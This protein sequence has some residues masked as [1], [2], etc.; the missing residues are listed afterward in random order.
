MNNY[1]NNY[2]DNLTLK[3]TPQARKFKSKTVSGRGFIKQVLP[4]VTE[5]YEGI[6]TPGK[7]RLALHVSKLKDLEPSTVALVVL[8]VCL[9]SLEEPMNCLT[10][11]TRVSQYLQQELNYS[12]LSEQTPGLIER[13]QGYRK[14]HRARQCIEDAV[15]NGKF[16]DIQDELIT[17][18]PAEG[19]KVGLV[20]LEALVKVNLLDTCTKGRLKQYIWSL[21]TLEWAQETYE[22]YLYLS[23]AYL[24]LIEEPLDYDQGINHSYGHRFPPVRFRLGANRN[25]EKEPE[26]LRNGL[27]L[28][29]ANTLARV[30]YQINEP[31]LAVVRELWSRGWE[32]GSLVGSKPKA[33]PV[34]PVNATEE[35]VLA[36]KSKAS[37]IHIA[38]AHSHTRR[39]FMTRQLSILGGYAK[40]PLY[41]LWRAD[42]R[43][44]LYPLTTTILNP[45]GDGLSKGLLKFHTSKARP[46]GRHGLMALKIEAANHY[47]IDK[48]ALTKRLE[49]TEEML[50]T[51]LDTARSPMVTVEFW[52][53]ADSPFQFLAACMELLA[54]YE[55]TDPEAY[56]SSYIVYFDGKCSGVQ[57][58]SALTRNE[59][60]GSLVGL[61][62]SEPTDNPPDIYTQILLSLIEVLKGTD[63]EHIDYWLGLLDQGYLDRSLVKPAAMTYVYGAT[64]RSRTTG[65]MTWLA[66]KGL[67]NDDSFEHAKCLSM[68]LN[69]VL[70]DRLSALN[71]GMQWVTECV[72]E[73]NKVT[74]RIT[75]VSP[76]GYEVTMAYRKTNTERVSVKSKALGIEVNQTATYLTD[77]LDKAKQAGSAPPNFIHSLDASHLV[78]TVLTYTESNHDD[79]LPLT[80]IH[81]SFGCLPSSSE[82]LKGIIKATF[83]QLYTDFDSLNS[84]KDQ[85]EERYG[86][87][88]SP[89]PAKGTL[90]I[91]GILNSAYA[92]V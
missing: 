32:V 6:L 15:T 45:Q 48:V 26:G 18:T 87:E 35:E 62:P 51:L 7:G 42:S 1:A 38:N 91:E 71:V 46:L 77:Q 41:F 33:I 19:H 79:E 66:D 24:P 27:S 8:V 21:S 5:L 69:G 76:V 85:L 2:T 64:L 13:I 90:S 17:W 28:D 72:R 70:K 40:H 74:D 58:W 73:L 43:G 37:H 23:P 16:G 4:A 84:F 57:H 82:F 11:A 54:A 10:V 39:M 80:V 20:L 14:N 63:E 52:S 59:D 25:S 30:P 81:D 60:T 61:L 29:A 36:W 83:V 56:E 53:K 47:G 55:S 68:I 92:F 86:V 89:P 44:R 67:K 31:V 3:D 34:F 50:D 78:A 12:T 9:D 88:L 65:I 49:W 75:W 22:R